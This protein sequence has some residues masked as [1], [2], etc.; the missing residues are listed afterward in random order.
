MLAA[1]VNARLISDRLGHSSVGFTLDV[2]SHLLPNAQAEAAEA[3]AAMLSDSRVGEPVLPE[4][5]AG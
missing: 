4:R 2:Y 5:K 3:L 1:G